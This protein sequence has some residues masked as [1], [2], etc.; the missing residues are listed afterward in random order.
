MLAVVSSPPMDRVA[1]RNSGANASSNAGVAVMYCIGKDMIG[2]MQYSSDLQHHHSCLQQITS[3][4]NAVTKFVN[5]L[6]G[7]ILAHSIAN[8]TSATQATGLCKATQST[9]PSTDL[10]Q[11]DSRKQATSH[12]HQSSCY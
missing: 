10:P 7:A 9:T 11:H 2:C 5:V 12:Q 1:H 4:S 8:L 3:L 6:H